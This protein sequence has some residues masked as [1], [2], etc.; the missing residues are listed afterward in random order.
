MQIDQIYDVA[1]VSVFGQGVEVAENLMADGVSVVLMDV[2]QQLAAFVEDQGQVPFG[3]FSLSDETL[4]QSGLPIWF[5]TGPVDLRGPLAPF[6]IQKI[7]DLRPLQLIYE[8]VFSTSFRHVD[9]IES[10]PHIPFHKPYLVSSKDKKAREE[11]F[12]LIESK[13][14]KVVRSASVNDISLTGARLETIEVSAPQT[15]TWALKFRQ[16][17]W[18]PTSEQTLRM[19]ES[20]GQKLFPWGVLKPMWYWSRCK[21]KLS[22]KGAEFIPPLCLIVDQ[23]SEVLSHQNLIFFK[24]D[25][26]TS[27]NAELWIKIPYAQRSSRHALQSLFERTVAI[28]RTRLYGARVE[29]DE[30]PVEFR[31]EIDE[32]GAPIFPVF[33]FDEQENFRGF[34]SSQLHLLSAESISHYDEEPV[35]TAEV[36]LM[37]R[38]KRTHQKI[39]KEL[40][41][42]NRGE[43]RDS[44][45]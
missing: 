27:E 37:A 12:K 3:H 38:V 25:L 5:R 7:K 14:A 30:M 13:G 1:I 2:T 26:D 6:Y 17:I 43:A 9:Q 34:K 45:I 35:R 15:G 33:A 32:C 20:L 44:E 39:M 19:K 18:T 41:K 40:A 29:I 28:L 36:H 10:T 16:L 22:D 24:R 8:G 31:R 21:I 23:E 11:R 42:K 4:E